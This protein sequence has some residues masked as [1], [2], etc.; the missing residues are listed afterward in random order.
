MKMPA[1]RALWI[2]VS[3]GLGGC[4]AIVAAE[5]A[6]EAAGEV[7]AEAV[8]RELVEALLGLGEGGGELL[9]GRLPGELEGALPLPPGSRVAGSLVRGGATTVAVRRR[10]AADGR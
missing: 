5:P 8:P 1:I 3:L 7:S 4:L 9:A 2:A 10:A 6:P